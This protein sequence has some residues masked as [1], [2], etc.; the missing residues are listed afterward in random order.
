[1]DQLS[2]RPFYHQLSHCLIAIALITLTIY[3]GQ[4]ILVPLAMAV[5]LSV[6]LRPVEA[7]LTRLGLP[8][9]LSI[10]IAVLLAVLL[11]AG[12]AV[13]L[14]MQ[15][16]D[17]SDE[18]PKLKRN[19]NDAYRDVRRWIRRE[20]SVSYRQQDQYLRPHQPGAQPDSGLLLPDGVVLPVIRCAHPPVPI[21]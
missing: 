10:S 18:L 12:V 1:M 21:R 5:L 9:V 6:L 8:K 4:D 14:S 15:L 20:Y 19:I 2:T 13:F 11:L 16:A 17:F 7:W 3:L